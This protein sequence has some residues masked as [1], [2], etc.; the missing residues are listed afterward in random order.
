MNLAGSYR[1]ISPEAY[2]ENKYSCG[3]DMWAFGLITYELITGEAPFF[4]QKISV[5]TYKK[6]TSPF[7]EDWKQR[8]P[9]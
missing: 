1:Y 3:S 9:K 8:I 6:K 5:E 7:P 4:G 2:L